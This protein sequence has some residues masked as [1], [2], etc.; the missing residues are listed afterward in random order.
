MN[1]TQIAQI[2]DEFPENQRDMPKTEFISK[3]MDC[4]DP[5]K[6]NKIVDAMVARK[7]QVHRGQIQKAVIDSAITRGK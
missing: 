6:C 3:F 1:R 7:R 2:Y 5:V 4:Q